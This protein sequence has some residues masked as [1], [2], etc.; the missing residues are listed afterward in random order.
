[1]CQDFRKI[2]RIDPHRPAKLAQTHPPLF[3]AVAYE[4]GKGKTRGKVHYLN[5]IFSYSF[6]TKCISLASGYS[7]MYFSYIFF[8]GPQSWS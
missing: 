3:H 8:A 4:I 2:G 7:L 6:V 1:M 5:L